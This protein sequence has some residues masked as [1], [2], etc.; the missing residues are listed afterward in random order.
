MRGH[1]RHIVQSLFIK[2]PRSIVDLLRATLCATMQCL[3]QTLF[4][5]P[6]KYCRI[7]F[8]IL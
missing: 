7:K 8:M 1:R 4:F 2:G 3:V 5:R 6:T